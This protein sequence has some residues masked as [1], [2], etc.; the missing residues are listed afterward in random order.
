MVLDRTDENAW[1][2]HYMSNANGEYEEGQSFHLLSVAEQRI[3]KNQMH[4]AS[5][6]WAYFY[7]YSD[8]TKEFAH[9]GAERRTGL[10][11][12]ALC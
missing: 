10:S 1:E 3:V 8:I 9:T 11:D 4:Y 12:E 7:V 2:Q 6:N 5:R